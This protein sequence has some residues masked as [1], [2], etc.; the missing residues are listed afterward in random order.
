MNFPRPSRKIKQDEK[1]AVKPASPVD[2]Q[3]LRPSDVF[4]FDPHTDITAYELACLLKRLYEPAIHF[5]SFLDLPEELKRHF[6]P[7]KS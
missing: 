2:P 5:K 4:A 1:P 7:S 6:R 3:R